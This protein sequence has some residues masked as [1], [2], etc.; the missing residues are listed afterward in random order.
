MIDLMTP[1]KTMQAYYYACQRFQPKRGALL[2]GKLVK[3]EA[4]IRAREFYQVGRL[5]TGPTGVV[6]PAE[7]NSNS[8]AFEGVFNKAKDMLDDLR[9]DVK[10]VKSGKLG[11][12]DK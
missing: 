5:I 6:K 1:L 2:K 12:D 10:D 7:E 11:R 9:H 8:R 3:L 4:T